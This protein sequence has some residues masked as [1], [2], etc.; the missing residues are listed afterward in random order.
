MIYGARARL[1]W[2]R[3][4]YQN[5]RIAAAGARIPDPAAQLAGHC[6]RIPGHG[7]RRAGRPAGTMLRSTRA[8]DRAPV[9]LDQA[10][11]P[12]A[13]GY[14]AGFRDRWSGQ[15]KTRPAV[16]LDGLRG[17]AARAVYCIKE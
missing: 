10:R 15:T 14:Y 17:A 13:G 16:S 12:G 2:P 5:P 4:P 9:G 8:T 3:G 6:R 7:S 1:N 11:P